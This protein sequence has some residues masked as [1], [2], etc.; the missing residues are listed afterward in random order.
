MSKA[1]ATHFRSFAEFYPFY[2]DEHR[3]RIGRRLHVTGTGLAIGT[4]AAGLLLRD[5][6]LLLATPL[7]GYGFAWVGHAAFEKNRPATFSHPL[8]SLMGDL[9][10]FGETVA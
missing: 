5:R 7:L 6:R 9:R 2:L 10:L 4:L 1:A 3:S 8:W